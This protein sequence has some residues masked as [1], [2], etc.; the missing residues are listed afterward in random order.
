[1]PNTDELLIIGIGCYVVVRSILEETSIGIKR[2]WTR[3][4]KTEIIR[5]V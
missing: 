1:M 3:K 4:K 2:K 5:S